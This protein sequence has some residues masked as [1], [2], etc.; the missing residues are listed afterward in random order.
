MWKSLLSLLTIADSYKNKN[1]QTKNYGGFSGTACSFAHW[2][3]RTW[4][5]LPQA[6]LAFKVSTKE[7]AI[8]LMKCHLTVFLNYSHS[9]IPLWLWFHQMLFRLTQETKIL[10][11][12]TLVIWVLD[13]LQ[14]CFCIFGSFGNLILRTGLTI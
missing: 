9:D 12:M 5:P 7:P 6:L 8:N 11:S 2:S 4:S 13:Q 3:F 10:S 1:K 14:T